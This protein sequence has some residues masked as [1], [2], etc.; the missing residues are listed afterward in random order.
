[1]KKFKENNKTFVVISEDELK[2]VMAD[3]CVN[4][5]NPIGVLIGGKIAGEVISNLFYKK[6]QEE[7]EEEIKDVNNVL[8]Q[9]EIGK[10]MGNIGEK[11]N[12]I[13]NGERLY[14][15]D[16]IRI[17]FNETNSTFGDFTDSFVCAY[18]GGYTIFG[19]RKEVEPSKTK[20][21]KISEFYK[22]SKIKSYKDIKDKEVLQFLKVKKEEK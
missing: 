5:G 19:I 12:F 3:A 15:G 20:L 4:V 18:E 14:V 22:L 1:M 17:T 13:L 2:S 11:T 21:D 9:K 7:I 6:T 16:V 10:I 8:Y